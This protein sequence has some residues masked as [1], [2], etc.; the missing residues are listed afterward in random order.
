MLLIFGTI[1][2]TRAQQ[3]IPL[4]DTVRV[5]PKQKRLR[6]DS[7]ERYVQINSIHIPGNKRTLKTIITG[8][9]RLKEGDIISDHDLEYVIKKDQQKLFN[10]HLFNTVSIRTVA[11]DST[12]IDLQVN[13]EERWFSF[14][15]P[16][17]QLSDRNFNEWWQNYNHDMSQVNYG[18]KLYQYNL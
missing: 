2:S 18:I 16:R 12:L 4:G 5:L 8:E 7:V 6:H 3:I 13:L 15:V 1:A 14:P 17:F 10:L 9:L 11:L